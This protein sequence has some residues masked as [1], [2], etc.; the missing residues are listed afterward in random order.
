MKH[1]VSCRVTPKEYMAFEYLRKAI[2]QIDGATIIERA[3]EMMEDMGDGEMQT[4]CARI[5]FVTRED[6]IVERFKEELIRTGYTQTEALRETI[7]EILEEYE[8]L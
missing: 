2:K 8:L 1:A 6:G 4:R 7:I 3:T 5:T